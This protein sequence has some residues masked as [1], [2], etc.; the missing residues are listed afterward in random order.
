[1][2]ISRDN[3]AAALVDAL[4]EGSGIEAPAAARISSQACALLEGY[5][6]AAVIPP[7]IL[8]LAALEVARELHTRLSA[9]GGIYSPFGEGAPVR[10]ARDPLTPAYPIIAPY[11]KGGFA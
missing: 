1:M 2:S 8:E 10:L 5:T 6:R 4:G 9:P 7:A 3:V 11:M